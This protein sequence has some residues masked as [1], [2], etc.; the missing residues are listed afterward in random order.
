MLKL[1]DE[2]Y[3]EFATGRWSKKQWF[4]ITDKLTTEIIDNKIDLTNPEKYIHASLKNIAHSHDLKNGKVDFE[5]RF[6][7]SKFPHYDWLKISE[8]LNK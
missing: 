5:K 2:F 8:G 7:N 1:T 6:K 4:I 3:T